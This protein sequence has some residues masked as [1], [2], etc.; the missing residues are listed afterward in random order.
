MKDVL[1]MMRPSAS[2]FET[3]AVAAHCAVLA[4]SDHPVSAKKDILDACRV[5][6]IH[7]LSM[8]VAISRIRRMPKDINGEHT[9]KNLITRF[10]LDDVD[11]ASVTTSDRHLR[12]DDKTKPLPARLVFDGNVFVYG[13]KDLHVVSGSVFH[14]L[15]IKN[16]ESLVIDPGVGF[17]NRPTDGNTTNL[18]VSNSGISDIRGLVG[19]PLELDLKYLPIENLADVRCDRLTVSACPRL[20]ELGE[21]VM[22]TRGFHLLGSGIRTLPDVITVRD[23][24]EASIW[25]GNEGSPLA[26]L[27]RIDVAGKAQL[28]LSCDGD[29]SLDL[30]GL[31]GAGTFDLSVSSKSARTITLSGRFDKVRMDAECVNLLHLDATAVESI[32]NLDLSGDLERPMPITSLRGVFPIAKELTMWRCPQWDGKIPEGVDPHCVIRTEIVEAGVKA[33]RWDHKMATKWRE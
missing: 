3:L 25:I 22:P 9:L 26:K 8:L 29:D 23:G 2:P 31:T 5:A 12:F 19:D 21:D 17:Y 33:E 32:Q 28:S 13:V 6:G 1:S 14:Y 16:V 11:P 24:F 30:S 4:L 10:G 7:P 18:S 15:D 27:P 20:R